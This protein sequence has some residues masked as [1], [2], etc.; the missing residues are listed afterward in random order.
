MK[1]EI[2]EDEAQLPNAN[3]RVVCW[4]SLSSTYSV[5][6]V[7]RPFPLPVFQYEIVGKGLGR[8]GHV[9]CHQVDT[10]K[11][12]PNEESRRP[13]LYCPSKAGY[14]SIRKADDRYRSLF[15]TPGMDQ[16]E[17]GILTVEHRPPSV[18]T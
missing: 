15:T 17:T 14:Q 2:A 8:S 10:R 12:V 5:S 16:R 9:R 3:G 1:E 7:P 18:S 13:V 11:A 4:V 6:L